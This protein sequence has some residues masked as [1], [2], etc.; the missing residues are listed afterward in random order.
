MN[1]SIPILLA[2]LSLIAAPA[3]TPTAHS[4]AVEP[5]AV[6]ATPIASPGPATVSA[7]TFDLSQLGAP[8]AALLPAD[9]LTLQDL[10][11]A[12]VTANLLQVF[13][14]FALTEVV[15]GSEFF[16]SP[17]WYLERDL[18]DR[19][20]LVLRK[21]VQIVPRPQNQAALQAAALGRLAALGIG[22]DEIHSVFQRRLMRQDESGGQFLAPVLQRYKTFVERGLNGIEVEGNRA[23][24]THHLDGS[25][26]RAW[27]NW[28]PLAPTGHKLRTT[29]S[30]NMI[31]ALAYS[32]LR[33]EQEFAGTV[34]LRWKYVPTLLPSGEI[35][36]ELMV[37]ARLRGPQNGP[38]GF[39]AREFDI[40]VFAF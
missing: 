12:S 16:E 40:G 10:E 28:P 31:V 9:P 25:L 7:L 35:E 17:N 32:K 5:T 15:A 26:H 19:A 27:I 13:E 2:G 18:E 23:V 6:A 21:P 37:G 22:P 1:T 8:P 3:T 30:K 11:P 4:T 24:I 38:T 36:L 29:M 20:T 39:E 14:P 34:Q 33:L